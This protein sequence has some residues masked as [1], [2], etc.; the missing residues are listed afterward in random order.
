MCQNVAQCL[1]KMDNADFRQ[2]GDYDDTTKNNR[3]NE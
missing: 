2:V 3:D 1:F